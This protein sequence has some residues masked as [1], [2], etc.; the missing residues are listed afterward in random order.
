MK[1]TL[2]FFLALALL[3]SLRALAKSPPAERRA[4]YQE[5][6]ARARQ[7]GQD[8][9]VYQR[10][11]DWNHLGEE[12]L[13]DVWNQP[14]LAAAVG[15]GS[16][17]VVV[18]NPETP[19]SPPVS[20]RAPENAVPHYETPRVSARQRLQELTDATRSRPVNEIEAITCANGSVFQHRV[21]GCFLA[22]GTN[23]A[24]EVLTLTLKPAQAGR[25]VRIDFPLDDSLPGHG[26]GRGGNGNFAISEVEFDALHALAAWATGAEGVFGAWQAIDGVRDQKDNAWNAAAH[27]HRPRTLLLAL[28]RSVPAGA[29]LT[30]R[31]VCRSQWSEHVPGC[32][33]ASVLSDSS[34]AADVL[35]VGR[36]EREIADNAAFTWRGVNLPRIAFLDCA[37]RPV[38]S[39]NKPRQGL[40]PATLAARLRE[41]RAVRVRRDTLWA[42]AEKET[43]PRQAEL[44]LEGLL[45]MD[46]ELAFD[47][48]Y[49]SIRDAIRAADPKDE[50]ACTRRLQFP[51][52]PRDVPPMVA[53]AYKLVDQKKYEEALAKLD[54][55]LEHPGNRRFSHEHL[56]RIL[57]GKFNVYR[58]WPGHEARRF[59]VQREIYHLDPTTYFGLGAIG[60]LAMHDQTPEPVGLSYGWS[61]CHLRPGRNAWTMSLDLARFF[62][63]AGK[64]CL[65]IVHQN[66]KDRVTICGVK[67]L[68][69]Q[70]VLSE[71]TP[72]AVLAPHNKVEVNLALAKWPPRDKLA[73]RLELEVEA[74]HTDVKGRFEVDPLL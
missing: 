21:D 6:L 56:Q 29:P 50:S 70:A 51:P 3:A 18:D 15:F 2:H 26:P 19:G 43:G 47:N 14:K 23:P 42:R 67:L 59:E 36:A 44:L 49:K 1:S 10:G 28:D 65:R 64:Y 33:S 11:S 57:N 39:E 27:D 69:G 66:G 38:A 25:V 61:P 48:S 40:T 68:D 58:R 53:E 5:A 71:A 46:Q 31:L 37:G 45:A 9:V 55:E 74:G 52:E 20:A 34:L 73:V 13:A 30:L 72:S 41:M 35:A 62:D 60:Y 17:L 32:V 7:T 24:Q 63:H 54:A 12:L 22:G 8:I 4:N 16:I